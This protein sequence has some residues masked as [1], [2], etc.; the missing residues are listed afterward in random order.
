MRVYEIV[1]GLYQS[2]T[3]D[4]HIFTNGDGHQ[5]DINALIDLEGDIDPVVPQRK[6]GDVYLYWPIDDGELK[7]PLTV[8][9][10]AQLISGLMD[11]G[12]QVLVHCR[13]GMNRASL[14]TG[15]VL[16]HRGM[17][18]EEAVKLLQ[19][20][21][22]PEVLSNVAFREWLMGERPGH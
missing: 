8:R 2:P 21:R 1:P 10:A 5:V 4:E 22:H 9:S 3:P 14:V 18:P 12:Y 15:R 19:E 17:E 16:I 20:R 13:A 11:A 6:I 7:D